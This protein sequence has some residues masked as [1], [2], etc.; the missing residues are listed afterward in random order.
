VSKKEIQN[1]IIRYNESLL[2]NA[3][4][5]PLLDDREDSIKIED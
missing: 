3:K 2:Q 1:G 4:S 5:N